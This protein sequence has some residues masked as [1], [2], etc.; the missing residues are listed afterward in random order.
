MKSE[1]ISVGA[2]LVAVR[3]GHLSRCNVE[4]GRSYGTLPMLSDCCSDFVL[5]YNCLFAVN[6]QEQIRDAALLMAH[7][8]LYRPVEFNGRTAF[9]KRPPKVPLFKP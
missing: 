2:Q 9:R 6:Q 5:D 1:P 4:I 8:H 3:H 7:A